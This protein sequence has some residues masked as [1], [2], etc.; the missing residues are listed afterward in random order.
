MVEWLKQL[1]ATNRSVW[2]GIV[3]LVILLFAGVLSVQGF[4]SG[5]NVKSMLLLASFLG[6]ASLGQTFCAL[7]GGIDLSIAYVI[8]AANIL[9][10]SLFNL[11]IPPFLSFLIVLLAGVAVGAL[12][13]LLTYR[14]QGQ[15]L[16]VTLGIGFTVVGGVQILT[17]IGS[18]YAGNVLGETP[19]WL[20]NFS[21]I[22]GTTFGYGVPPVPLPANPPAGDANY[23]GGCGRTD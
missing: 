21:S 11:G 13:G 14:V 2:I 18:A 7:L 9:L 3:L 1:F 12:N 5:A 19:Q 22:A 17:S 15:A 20:A 16:I 4:G 8:G 23:G 10:A 6:L